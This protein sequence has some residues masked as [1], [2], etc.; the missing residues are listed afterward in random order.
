MKA[1]SCNTSAFSS[2]LTSDFQFALKHGFIDELREMIAIIGGE[3]P[4]DAF[5][6]Q[7][8]IQDEQKPKYYQGLSIGGKK[9]TSWARERSGGYQQRRDESVPPLLQAAFEG[10]LA[11]VEWF[12]S[13]TP[14]RLYKEYGVNNADDHRLK[15][16]A[17]AHGGLDQAVSSWLKRRSESVLAF[18][19]SMYPLSSR[20][21]T[22]D[23]P[24][25]LSGF[26]T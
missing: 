18:T 3:L 6:K 10:G 2:Y 23:F 17:K 22:L 4:L 24:F 12:L 19:L 25:P 21:G 11:A 16:L 13:D 26:L 1:N 20:D 7:S 5:V 14:F 8:G 15:M 9:M